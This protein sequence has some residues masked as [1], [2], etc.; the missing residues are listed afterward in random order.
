M[1]EQGWIAAECNRTV[2]RGVERGA[3]SWASLTRKLTEMSSFIFRFVLSVFPARKR[4][5]AATCSALYCRR[6][7]LLKNLWKNV[8]AVAT[9]I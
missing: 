4:H 1:H 8:I 6:E 3:T 9:V 7:Y 2:D 5:V